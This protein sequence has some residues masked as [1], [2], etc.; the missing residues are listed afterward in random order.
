MSKIRSTQLSQALISGCDS[1]ADSLRGATP[2]LTPKEW[3]IRTLC[4]ENLLPRD[5]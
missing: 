5:P 2:E 4:D 1:C 3:L